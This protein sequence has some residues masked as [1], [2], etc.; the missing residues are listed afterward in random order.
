MSRIS[1]ILTLLLSA[2][3]LIALGYWHTVNV[4]PYGH[5]AMMH[6]PYTVSYARALFDQPVD[7][8]LLLENQPVRYPPLTY[9]VA[10]VVAKL[11][12]WWTFFYAATTMLFMAVAL[13]ALTLLGQSEAPRSWRALLPVAA[14]LS[15][16]TFWEIGG[17]YNL[18]AGLFAGVATFF[19][20]ML[21][22]KRL[23]RWW[24][25][26]PAVL[27]V[28]ALSLSKGVFLVFTIPA[29]FA[30]ILLG[31]PELRRPRA[32]LLGG[33]AALAGTWFLLHVG[34][35]QPELTLDLYNPTYDPGA[36]FYPR[37]LLFG[38][39]GLPLFAALAVVFWWRWR[40]R[41][42]RRI[43]AVYALWFLAP[44]VFY[45]LVD[46]K[47]DWYILPAYLAA[48]VWFISTVH[49][50]IGEKRG[51]ILAGVVTAFYLVTA[52]A[53]IGLELYAAQTPERTHRVWGMKRPQPPTEVETA[54]AQWILDDLY[55]DPKRTMIVSLPELDAG[56]R[57]SNILPVM[58]RRLFFTN[59]VFVV[60]PFFA[61]TH[62]FVDTL[63]KTTRL[64]GIDRGWPVIDPDNI[65][66]PLPGFDY[67]GLAARL[68]AEE[69]N[70]RLQR[71]EPLPEGHTLYVYENREPGK[72]YRVN[73][74]G[75][76]EKYT[77]ELLNHK[78]AGRWSDAD[79]TMRQLRRVAVPDQEPGLN[80]EEAHIALQVDDKSRA[81]QLLEQNLQHAPAGRVR[82]ESAL[83]LARLRAELGDAP[84]ARE[85]LAAV[86][87]TKIDPV[88]LAVTIGEAARRFAD[89]DQGRAL[90]AAYQ[91]KLQ[92]AAAVELVMALGKLELDARRDEAALTL[93]RQARGMAT[94]PVRVRWLDETITAIERGEHR[95]FTAK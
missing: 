4:L 31:E 9:F 48:P 66:A 74:L 32:V 11:T 30:L 17:D 95:P 51:R 5:D 47:R 60:D 12:G 56:F 88:S 90:I 43:D 41:N 36:F 44:L 57:L 84:G 18:E 67:Q 58:D 59:Q 14:L 21:A 89:R 79:V 94:D 10:A 13:L 75:L 2:F 16:P 76:Y 77:A 15:V 54:A 70:W 72:T 71:R 42:W 73:G 85:A 7:L 38:Y 20:A 8:P 93:F 50:F 69:K 55:A 3:A 87:E 91:G 35:V 49:D 19:S 29:G 65:P 80:L 23:Q 83:L 78:Q 82:A 24:L 46:T 33:V 22:A 39:H 6:Q 25:L 34:L 53:H 26:I 62:E 81:A 40:E 52:A 27:V 28:A 63:A 61:V 92:G 68:A 45:F 64:Y 1:S 86:D 37:L